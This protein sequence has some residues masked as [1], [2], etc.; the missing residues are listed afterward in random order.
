[1]GRCP[2]ATVPGG[3]QRGGRKR[4]LQTD[5][6]NEIVQEIE[7]LLGRQSIADLD[8]EAI[9]MAAGTGEIAGLWH[10]QTAGRRGPGRKGHAIN[11]AGRASHHTRV[12]RP[13]TPEQLTGAVT[14]A[15]DVCALGVLLD[16]LLTGQHPVGGSTHSPAELVKAIVDAQPRRLS[17]IVMHVNGDEE[18]LAANAVRR[19]TS[20]D[21]LRRLLLGDLDTI[22]AQALKK[23]PNK[24]YASVAALADD[25]VRYLNANPSAHDRT[26]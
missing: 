17:D 10:C 6:Q 15:L 3:F 22:V 11:H 1:M 16:V 25:L 12:C 14:T 2:I 9:E 19:T 8:F 18:A 21:K 23:E 26:R 5:L 24:R 4:G 20:P 7:T 13:G